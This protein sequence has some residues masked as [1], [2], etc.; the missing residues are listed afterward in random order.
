MTKTSICAMTLA[1]ILTTVL[2]VISLP[3]IEAT[4]PEPCPGKTV[5]VEINGG[6]PM[7]PFDIDS[8][9]TDVGKMKKDNMFMFTHEVD[10][11]L[12]TKMLDAL[13]NGDTVDIH[14][15]TCKITGGGTTFKVHT[16]WLTGGSVTSVTE[17]SGDDDD[18]F[19]KEKI[20]GK[21]TE[22]MRETETG[23]V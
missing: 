6:E 1:V 13:K 18:D 7:G 15:S 22:I 5:T 21:F 14:I 9:S 19:P 8:Y 3:T 4:A 12:S 10:G 2:L 23:S 20:K 11:T 16:V 17:T